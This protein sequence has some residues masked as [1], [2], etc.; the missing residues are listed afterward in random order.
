MKHEHHLGAPYALGQDEVGQDEAG[1]GGSRQLWGACRKAGCFPSHPAH[2]GPLYP[3]PASAQCSLQELTSRHNPGPVVHP[4]AN[5]GR[6]HWGHRE[7]LPQSSRPDTQRP[8]L[9]VVG[10]GVGAAVWE[11][12]AARCGNC[13]TGRREGG[14]RSRASKGWFGLGATPHGRLGQ[15]NTAVSSVGTVS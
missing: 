12:K 14:Q 4:P 3:H 11:I 2:F 5:T 6:R 1:R 13:R 8:E 9:A 15:G 7:L 10:M